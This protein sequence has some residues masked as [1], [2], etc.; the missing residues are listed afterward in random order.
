MSQCGRPDVVLIEPPCLIAGTDCEINVH[1]SREVSVGLLIVSQDGHFVTD[2]CPPAGRQKAIR[3]S[4]PAFQSCRLR[5]AI[6]PNGY[7]H[8]QVAPCMLSLPEPVAQE[9][10]RLFKGIERAICS[11]RKKR[12][13]QQAAKIGSVPAHTKR[14]QRLPQAKELAWCSH[15]AP[16][17]SRFADLLEGLSSGSGHLHQA[18][19]E[20]AMLF[21]KKRMWAS[22]SFLLTA[23][24]ESGASVTLGPYALLGEDVEAARLRKDF[25]ALPKG[26]AGL[27]V[28]EMAGKMG[29][30]RLW[31]M[32]MFT[33]SS[34]GS[35]GKTAK[36]G[37][38]ARGGQQADAVLPQSLFSRGKRGRTGETCCREG[39]YMGSAAVAEK[40]DWPASAR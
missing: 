20:T 2:V 8:N 39:P 7:G 13:S 35:E 27:T 21:L 25:P 28:G 30:E 14:A 12:E 23:C 5:V 24:L 22:A 19:A 40:L 11:K 34:T 36:S 16:L 3:I 1:M 18:C 32:E 26:A 31:T 10:R 29:P 15:F 6:H 33:C 38:H 9:F 17:C 4:L 37:W